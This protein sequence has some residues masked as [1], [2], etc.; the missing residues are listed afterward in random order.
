MS[1]EFRC[2]GCNKIGEHRIMVDELTLNPA[3][4]LPIGWLDTSTDIDV[5]MI[6]VQIACSR[7]CAERVSEMQGLKMVILNPED[8][9]NG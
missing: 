6:D 2:D 7:E 5:N 3:W 1:T 4:V 8:K 9:K